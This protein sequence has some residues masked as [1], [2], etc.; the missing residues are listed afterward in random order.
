MD[1][2]TGAMGNLV[3]KLLQ[4]L[5]VEY[6]LQRGVRAEVESLA[7]ELESMHVAL[8]KV[9]EVRQDQLDAQVRLWARDAREASYDMEDVLDT[10]LVRVDGGHQAPDADRGKVKRLL[11]KMRKLFSLSKLR[12]RHDI[13]GAIEDIKTQ[14][15]EMAKRRDRYVQGPDDILHFFHIFRFEGFCCIN[16]AIFGFFSFTYHN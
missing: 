12:A 1:L 11:E 3:P 9:A 14:V 16:S 5:Q 2:V 15:D 4:L 10:F 6:N 8:A 13:A 7:R